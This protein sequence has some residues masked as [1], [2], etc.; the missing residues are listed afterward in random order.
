MPSTSAPPGAWP[1][2][3]ALV[4]HEDSLLEQRRRAGDDELPGMGQLQR[5]DGGEQR[6]ALYERD[7]LVGERRDHATD[8]LG[9]QD[10]QQGLE[11]GHPDRPRRLRLSSVDGFDAGTHDL[12]LEPSGVEAEGDDA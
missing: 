1:W 9:N 3:A 6:R 12:R 8:R 7:Q 5:G 4:I 2:P 11:P 10:E